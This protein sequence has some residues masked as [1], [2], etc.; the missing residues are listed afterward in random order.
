MA[1][2]M[3]IECVDRLL[4]KLSKKTVPFGGIPFIGIGDFRQTGPVL[5]GTNAEMVVYENSIKSSPLWT[6]FRAIEL[7]TPVRMAD[8]PKYDSWVEEIGNGSNGIAIPGSVSFTKVQLTLIENQSTI[9]E[10]YEF[11]YGDRNIDNGTMDTYRRSLLSPINASVDEFND[12]VLSKMAG[13]E[14]EC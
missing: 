2:R 13:E 11:L 7:C 4:R 10:S 6:T 3:A 8:D 12:M 9:E 5:K 1:N 14:G